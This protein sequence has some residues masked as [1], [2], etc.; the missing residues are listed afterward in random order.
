MNKTDQEFEQLYHAN[1]D[2]VMRLCLGYVSGDEDMAKDLVQE[3]F[4]KVWNSLSEFRNDSHVSTWIYRI[5]VNTCLMG[6][7]KKKPYALKME[8]ESDTTIE[9]EGSAEHKEM[10]FKEMYRCIN[11]LSA[12][13]KA[14][15]LM[16]LEGLAQKEIAAV[17]GM[18]HTAI[19]TRIHR[20]KTQLSKCVHHG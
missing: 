16:E 12:T 8:M 2:Q 4:V 14:I 7:R 11:T 9:D 20:I 17:M 10:Q 18:N 1:Y 6:L 3:V 15:I 13:N 19:R 5:A